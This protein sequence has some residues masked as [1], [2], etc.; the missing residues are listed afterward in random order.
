MVFDFYARIEC[1]AIPVIGLQG[2]S[3]LF[4][5]IWIATHYCRDKPSRRT[6]RVI[7]SMCAPEAKYQP[8]NGASR[9]GMSQN[10]S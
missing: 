8:V 6:F 1:V 3:D 9:I 4:V 5:N 10:L 7:P 2:V